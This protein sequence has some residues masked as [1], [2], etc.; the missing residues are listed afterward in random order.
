MSIARCTLQ[1]CWFLSALVL[2]TSSVGAAPI[3]SRL[4]YQVGTKVITDGGTATVSLRLPS[5]EVFVRIDL[6]C[7]TLAPTQDTYTQNCFNHDACVRA[8][9]PIERHCDFMFMFC[10]SDFFDGPRCRPFVNAISPSSGPVG[11]H[12]T[13]TGTNLLN[14][15]AVL[16]A[17]GAPRVRAEV[18][19]SR[20]KSLVCTVPAGAVTGAVIVVNNG[21]DAVTGVFT[22]AN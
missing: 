4:A 10:M 16:F 18:V 15:T 21:G 12:V 19:E 6:G 8:L 13:I 17:A 7:G 20:S 2:C 3:K 1:Q 9:G 22:V 11:T 5:K 14:P